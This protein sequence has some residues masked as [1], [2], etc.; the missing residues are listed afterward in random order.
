MKNLLTF[1]LL[2]SGLTLTT[3]SCS[4]DD[5]SEP[6]PTP[7][8]E[9]V[10]KI[11]KELEKNPEISIFTEDLKKLNIADVSTDEL[12]VFAARNEAFQETS[13]ASVPPSVRRHIA[14]GGYTIDQLKDSMILKSLMDD[15]LLVTRKENQLFINGILL[16]TTGVKVGKSVIYEVR[17]MIPAIEDIEDQPVPV[18]YHTTIRV[19]R[20]N[21]EWS[22]E[23]AEEAFPLSDAKV[24]VY[25]YEYNE[26]GEAINVGALIGEGI[27]DQEGHFTIDHQEEL[28]AFKA[29]KGDSLTNL[30]NGLIVE[31]VFTTQQ[32]TDTWAQYR[33]PDIYPDGAKV[34]CLK[35]QDVNADGLVD[36]N[37]KVESAPLRE[38]NL[39]E[40]GDVSGFKVYLA[41]SQSVN[42]KETL[43]QAK[44]ECENLFS[45]YSH[46][47]RDINNRLTK[48]SST[49]MSELYGTGLAAISQELWDNS[50]KALQFYKEAN[51]KFYAYGCP[52]SITEQWEEY[53]KKVQMQSA[54]IYST[55]IHFYG[56]AYL[57]EDKVGTSLKY[58]VDPIAEYLNTLEETLPLS[59]KYAVLA[60]EA[61]I[62]FNNTQPGND[63][64]EKVKALCEMIIN[65]GKFA[66]S[67]RPGEV[68][69]TAESKASLSG[70]YLDKSSLKKGQY[71][72]PVRYEEVLFM[73][74]EANIK[75]G[76]P[77]GALEIV[78]MWYLQQGL[79]PMLPAGASD[80]EILAEVKDLWSRTFDREGFDYVNLRRWDSFMEYF[81]EKGIQS[82]KPHNSLLPIPQ[83]VIDTDPSIQQNP[84]Y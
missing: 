74:A 79:P 67:A 62:Y 84:G 10:D 44:E 40:E 25:K 65:S 81:Q 18:T 76:I 49:A 57:V 42:W 33:L 46:T 51:K 36:I 60:A 14:K 7:I 2:L 71:Y 17:E 21:Q 11:V 41:S 53:N 47:L 12:T 59:L 28:L 13:K 3:I 83:D 63:R 69:Q 30:Y 29:Y 48:A 58:G 19:L 75:L 61:R 20:C 34:G 37:D 5:D 50:Y 15:S 77:G 23:N 26:Q 22:P 82:V 54:I 68:F 56:G 31:G 52:S 43:A 1:A 4:S 24:E 16:E 6:V 80:K 64:Y 9:Q 55:L 70:G 45:E 73:L 32:E 66:L 35:L 78:N 27:T 72:H 39:T 8:E 38:I